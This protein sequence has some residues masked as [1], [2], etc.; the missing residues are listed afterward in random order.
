M[1]N[2]V[3]V[4][5][6]DV[7]AA[8]AVNA[9]VVGFRVAEILGVDHQLHLREFTSTISA[10]PSVEALSTTMTSISLPALCTLHPE[11][12]IANIRANLRGHSKRR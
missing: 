11:T 1:D 2:G 9:D 8:T 7:F 3:W 6:K 10:V 4:E 5:Q 12:A